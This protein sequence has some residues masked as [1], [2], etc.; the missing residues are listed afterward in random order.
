[1]NAKLQ[2]I[3]NIYTIRTQK[4]VEPKVDESVLK[5]SRYTKQQ[6]IL[7]STIQYYGLIKFDLSTELRVRSMAEAEGSCCMSK[8]STGSR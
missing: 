5:T 3:K 4:R 8:E 2:K 6:T 1:M 7:Y